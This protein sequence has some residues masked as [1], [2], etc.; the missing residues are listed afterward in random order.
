M[1]F[2]HGNALSLLGRQAALLGFWS[3]NVNAG[4]RK[5]VGGA[6]QRLLESRE[7]MRHSAL[8]P[9]QHS[10]RARWSDATSGRAV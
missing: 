2:G 4:F 8:L 10:A 5:I 1:G 9:G 7:A 6:E 3:S